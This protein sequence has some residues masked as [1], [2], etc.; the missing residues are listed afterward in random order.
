LEEQLIWNDIMSLYLWNAIVW[1]ILF[2][3][4][5]KLKNTLTSIDF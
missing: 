4:N 1:Q 3:F 5:W 2:P